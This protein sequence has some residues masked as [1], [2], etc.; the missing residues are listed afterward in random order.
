MS[1]REIGIQRNDH[2]D[3]KHAMFELIKRIELKFK[4]GFW[5]KRK[6]RMVAGGSITLRQQILTTENRGDRI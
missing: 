2:Q 3:L 6:V 5:G 4:D 1:T